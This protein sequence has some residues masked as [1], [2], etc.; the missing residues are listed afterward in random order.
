MPVLD[1]ES[2]FLESLLTA[3]FSVYVHLWIERPTQDAIVANIKVE[4]G[5][6]DPKIPKILVEATNGTTNGVLGPL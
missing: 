3:F 4:V 1:L 5:I 2:V 6:P